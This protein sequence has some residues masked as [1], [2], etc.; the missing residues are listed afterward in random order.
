MQPLFLCPSARGKRAET[1]I[2]TSNVTHNV[3]HKIQTRRIVCLTR[4]QMKI[5][6][7]CRHEIV[8]KNGK[9]PLAIRFTH[10][11]THKTVSLGISVEAHYWDKNTE[12]ITANCPERAVLQSQID[13]TLAGYRKKIQRLEALDIPVNFDTLFD[14]KSARSVGITIK[15]GFNKIIYKSEFIT[16]IVC[17]VGV[18]F[19][20]VKNLNRLSCACWI[21]KSVSPISIMVTLSFTFTIIVERNVKSAAIDLFY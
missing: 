6:T 19:A 4:K 17:Y 15:E 18:A 12:M 21:L 16:L 10:R 7:I 5:K 1:A 11:R 2:R 14:A 3:T 8:Y 13:S 9:S 20:E